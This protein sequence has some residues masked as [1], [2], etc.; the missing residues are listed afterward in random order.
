MYSVCADLE[1]KLF[2]L[3]QQTYVSV[4]DLPTLQFILCVCVC[5]CVYA[6]REGTSTTLIQKTNKVHMLSLNIKGFVVQ[7][8][9]SY[10]C[11]IYLATTAEV[12]VVFNEQLAQKIKKKYN[13]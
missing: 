2:T 1:Q 11:R 4:S 9:H 3:C 8:V 12:S 5:V 13:K 10:S 7:R 6:H